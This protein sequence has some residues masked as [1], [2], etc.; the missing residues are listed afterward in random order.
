MKMVSRTSVFF[1]FFLNSTFAQ[2]VHF[3]IT[4]VKDNFVTILNSRHSGNRIGYRFFEHSPIRYGEVPLSPQQGGFNPKI[5]SQ[6]EDQY[7]NSPNAFV[8]TQ[9]IPKDKDWV[10]QN[11]TFYMNPINDGIEIL[12]V[13][14]TFGE[15]LPEYYGVQQCFRMTGETNGSQWRK[16]I[17]LTPAFSEYDLWAREGASKTSLTY[18]VRNGRWERLTAQKEAVG[19]R[20]PAGMAID[21]LRT[22]GQPEKHVGP[23][24]A[25]MLAPIDFPLIARMD[26][27]GHWICGIYWENASHVTD[28]HPADCLHSIINIGGV[29]PFSKRAFRGKIYWFEGNTSDLLNHYK[30]DF[31]QADGKLRIAACQ[32][33]VNGK[34]SENAN[35]IKKQMRTAKVNGTEL[36]HFPECALSGYGGADWKDIEALDWEVLRRETRSIMALAKELRMWVILGSSH[37]L[38][39]KNKPHN[40]LYVIDPHGKIIDRYD[41]RFC[42][43]GDL[44]YYSPGDHFVD[45]EINGIKCGLLICYDI[46]FPELYREYR[47]L[48]VDV[49]FQSFYNAR[50]VED[51]IHPKIMPV[52]AQVRAAT[53]AFF[54]S[55]TNSS[56]PYSWPCYFIQPDGLVEQKLCRNKPGILYADI[57]ISQKYYDASKP[58]RMDAI[59][60]KL[61]SGT[62]VIDERSKDRTSF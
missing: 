13:V 62:S 39:G 24:E 21:F 60:G 4:T 41:K 45:F 22:N 14:E 11:W 7:K 54:M 27:S 53:N 36:V 50:H 52:S 2:N 61:N 44:K 10:K 59:N 46:R 30:S 8:F 56:A 40:S 47:K 42:T 29:P 19:A 3:D 17:A 6:L 28:H 25:E 57:D 48:D 37:Q 26:K 9:V 35:W 31:M 16:A 51:C 5:V 20:T 12:L 32:F 43:T 49:I 34:I 23:Y 1:L 55:L 33:P 58:Y 15:G 38:S 18:V